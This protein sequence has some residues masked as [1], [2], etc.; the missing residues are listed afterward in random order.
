VQKVVDLPVDKDLR[1]TARDLLEVSGEFGD[2][3]MAW[4]VTGPYAL[5]GNNGQALFDRAFPP[6]QAGAP[7]VK[8]QIMPAGALKARPWQLDLGKLYGGDHRVAYARTWVYSETA[9]P[10]RLELGS[11]D[12]IKAWLNGKVVV[13]ANRGG[14]VAP[15]AEK[16]QVA[17][18]QG[19]NSLLLKVTQWTSGWG[20]CARLAKP[21]GTP[22]PGVRTALNLPNQ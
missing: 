15:G 2:F 20:F 22:L 10:A 6:E 4:E 5:E 1:Q 18:Q 8:W 11:D 16:A 21:D 19:W 14:D 3:L 7:N 13:T 17:L 9:Q 12:G